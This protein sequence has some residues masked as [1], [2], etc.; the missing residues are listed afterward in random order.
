MLIFCIIYLFV[1]IFH[2]PKAVHPTRIL[3]ELSKK[4]K[5]DFCENLVKRSQGR[6]F[7]FEK[8]DEPIWALEQILLSCYAK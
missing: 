4:I 1:V 8:D 7:I 6:V 3:L 5:K 2:L